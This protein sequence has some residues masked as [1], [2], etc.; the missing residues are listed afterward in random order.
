MSNNYHLIINKNRGWRG[1]ASVI[2]LDLDTKE[3][4]ETIFSFSSEMWT[5][6]IINHTIVVQDADN[7]Y[8]VKFSDDSG[9]LPKPTQQRSVLIKNYNAKVTNITKVN[10][11]RWT[12]TLG[13]TWA[14]LLHFTRNRNNHTTSAW[15]NIGVR[16]IPT[17]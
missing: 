5:D 13:Y 15:N 16:V 4:I 7:Y 11:A 6:L 9:R 2:L 3:K 1:L 12:E 8:V 14:S 17:I 10:K